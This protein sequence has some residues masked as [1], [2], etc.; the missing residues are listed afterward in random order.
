M[1]DGP[2][3]C[4][5]CGTLL[6]NRKVCPCCGFDGAEGAPVTLQ[7]SADAE[8]HAPRIR[9]VT[10]K[11]G[12]KMCGICMESTPEDQLVEQDGQKICPNCAENLRNKA[13]RKLAGGQ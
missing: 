1:A 9:E 5:R 12:V 3:R 11:A 6:R 4:R 10:A 8:A 13:A 2:N 7:V